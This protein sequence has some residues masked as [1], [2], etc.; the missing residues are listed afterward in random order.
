[1]PKIPELKVIRSRDKQE[2][3]KQPDF[4]EKKEPSKGLEEEIKQLPPILRKVAN[5]CLELERLPA[6]RVICE[7][8]NL[9]E[10]SVK[11]A[12][13][14]MAKDKGKDFRLFLIK[15][16]EDVSRLRHPRIEDIAFSIASDVN[17]DPLVRLK[18]A[19]LYAKLTGTLGNKKAEGTNTVKAALPAPKMRD[20][21]KPE[22]LL[23][24]G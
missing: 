4:T 2:R 24:A 17:E 12:I 18:G 3:E 7:K 6:L 10:K 11:Q 14:R 15:I 16:H 22:N 13:I 8:A 5:A 23:G 20:T 21:G 1:M 19:E 9:N